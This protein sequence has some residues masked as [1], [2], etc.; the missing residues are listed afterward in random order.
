MKSF[1]TYVDKICMVSEFQ[2]LPWG[3]GKNFKWGSAYWYNFNAYVCCYNNISVPDCLFT[4]IDTGVKIWDLRDFDE[5]D[6][7]CLFMLLWRRMKIQLVNKLVLV[8]VM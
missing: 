7:S 6:G 2:T 4:Q 3:F 8:H 5:P 1:K